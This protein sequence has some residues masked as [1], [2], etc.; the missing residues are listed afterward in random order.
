MKRKPQGG[1]RPAATSRAA[2][3]TDH[4]QRQFKSPAERGLVLPQ[5]GRT[6]LPAPLRRR[7]L[8]CLLMLRECEEDE[9]LAV[10]QGLLEKLPAIGLTSIGLGT[11]RILLFE[12]QRHPPVLLNPPFC[13]EG[14]ILL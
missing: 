4:D 2:Q 13:D 10:N 5:R 9:D 3:G 14:S 11:H 8:L 7:S 1:A 6:P 12:R